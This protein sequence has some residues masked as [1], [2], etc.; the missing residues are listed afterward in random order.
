MPQEM[1][2]MSVPTW[3]RDLSG[4]Q[5]VYELYKL[6]VELGRIVMK[7]PKKY[8]ANYG[9]RLITYGLDA[10]KYAQ[11]ANAIYMNA[12]TSEADYLT[13]RRHLQSALALSDSISTIADIFLTL[14]MEVDGIEY[15]KLEK[16]QLYVGSQTKLCHDLISG[17]IKSDRRVFNKNK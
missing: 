4:I 6:N 5:Y 1:R 15:N 2:N 17:V 3:E 12:N 10:L 13:R 7:K 9:D 8:R 14:N 11:M 16:E